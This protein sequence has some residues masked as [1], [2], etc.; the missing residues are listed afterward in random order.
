MVCFFAAELDLPSE[1]GSIGRRKLRSPL[2][3]SFVIALNSPPQA[4]DLFLSTLYFDKIGKPGDKAT[5]HLMKA[6]TSCLL[7]VLA[8][9]EVYTGMLSS[10]WTVGVNL[11]MKLAASH[12]P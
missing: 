2:I 10:H 8:S 6:S 7:Q 4:P 3:L 12:L 5:Y 9:L 1:T 11:M